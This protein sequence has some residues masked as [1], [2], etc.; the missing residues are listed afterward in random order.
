MTPFEPTR[1][2]GI[3][4][5]ADFAPRA[6]I[7]YATGRNEDRGPGRPAAVS[8]LSPWLRH[9]LLTEEEVVGAALD[10]Q[11]PQRAE[12]FIQEV[13]WRSYW[14]GW[15]EMR[16]AVWGAYRARV[17][18]AWGAL[19]DD[20]ALRARFDA[21]VEGRT[22]ID[23]FDAWAAELSGTGWLH[24]HA[25]MWFASIWCFTLRLPWVLGADHFLRHLLD[26]DAA[27]NT[28]SWRWV[29]GTQTRGKHYVARAANIARYT[30][31]R[32]DPAGQLEEE[33]EPIVEPDPPGGAM[34]LAPALP[35][36]AGRVALLLHEDD[37]GVTTLDLGA[38]EVVAV[39]GVAVPEAR[40]PRGCAPA[41]AAWTRAALR[42][43]L[44][45]AE[46][47]FGV[48]AHA[49]PPEAIADWAAAT[50]TTTVVTPWAPVGWTADMLDSV[51]SALGASGVRLH[52]LR[53]AWDS[54]CWPLATR[55]FF[56]F[57]ENIPRLLREL[58]PQPP[59]G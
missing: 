8:A 19:D 18:D 24:N 25:R 49:M 43:G 22:G 23:S 51:E 41:V 54:A 21:A 55:G 9:R 35:A 7:A 26:G 56:P 13:F 10:A 48:P 4:R 40:S 20:P 38:A 59:E 33:P 1:A 31:G 12:K 14:K 46:A 47:R 28:L 57:R 50:G 32:F 6:G 30:D 42:D 15:L 17:A 2:A 39:A 27:S 45:A 3:A 5:L 36:P 34:R 52:R 53:R 16:P 29:I 11:G 37:L 58:A 44:V